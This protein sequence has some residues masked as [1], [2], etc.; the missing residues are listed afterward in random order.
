MLAQDVKSTDKS[1]QF[2]FVILSE[3]AGARSEGRLRKATTQHGR[4]IREVQAVR[5]ASL[6]YFVFL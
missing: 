5:K 1:S 3:V 6:F 4:L 2:Q